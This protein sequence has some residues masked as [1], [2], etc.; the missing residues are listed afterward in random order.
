MS[1]L[2]RKYHGHQSRNGGRVPYWIHP[3]S[4]AEIVD[5][6]ISRS[7]EL[8]DD[9]ALREDIFLAAQGHDLYE[10]TEI[11][12]GLVVHEFGDRVH[13]L[14]VALTNAQGDH[15]QGSYVSQIQAGPDEAKLVKLA[16]LVDNTFSCAYGLHDVGAA[17]AAEF[18]WPIGTVMRDALAQR[19]PERYPVTARL[20]TDMLDF[21]FERLRFN[22]EKYATIETPSAGPLGSETGT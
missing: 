2:V 10:D 21:G 20:L 12:R 3:Q 1:E 19:G 8:N 6:A 5:C 15:E 13:A 18:F 16:D 17:F 22:L 14:I 7:G 11:P 4:V 9:E